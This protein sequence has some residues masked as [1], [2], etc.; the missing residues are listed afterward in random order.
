MISESWPTLGQMFA[1]SDEELAEV[2]PMVMNLVIAKGIPS[3]AELN[4]GHYVQLASTWAEEIRQ[5]L[6][7]GEANF[8]RRPQLW[9]ND[10]GVTRTSLC[11]R[12]PV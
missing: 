2:D 7:G 6:P 3:L 5:C 1:L 12:A 8:Y 4:I 9:Q 10:M 11:R